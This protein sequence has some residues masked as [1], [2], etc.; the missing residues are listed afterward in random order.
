MNS[1][2]YLVALMLLLIM[3]SCNR[4]ENKSPNIETKDYKSDAGFDNNGEERS[5]K[6]A[7]EKQLDGNVATADSTS[8]AVDNEKNK[9]T[10]EPI[11]TNID[12]DKKI[13]KTANVSLDVKDFNGFNKNL[14]GLVKRFGAYLA[15]EEQNQNEYSIENV[16]TIKVPVAQF[17]DMM[18]ALAGDGIKIVERKISTEDVTSEIVDTKGRIEAKKAVRQQYMTLLNQAK[19]MHDILEVQNEINAI[20]EELEAASGRVN[21]LSHQS[22]YSTIHLKYYQYLDATLKPETELSFWS[23]TKAAFGSGAESV[24]SFLLFII[25]LWPYILIAIAT[26][27]AIK[28]WKMK[29][30]TKTKNVE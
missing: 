7:K 26:W 28:K 11:K 29:V 27:L 22:A 25:H 14:H 4:A 15:S 13:I 24:G 10:K 19:N 9:N 8:K 1:T 20:T 21:Y 5:N 2:K 23:K 12:W 18:N 6:A 17:E 16:V 30:A 3:Y